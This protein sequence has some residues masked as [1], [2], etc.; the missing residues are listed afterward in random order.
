MMRRFWRRG[1]GPFSKTS[2]T[3]GC[4]V[5]MIS[6]CDECSGY[7]GQEMFGN[8]VFGTPVHGGNVSTYQ[9]PVDERLNAPAKQTPY[10][11]PA[12]K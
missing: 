5:G 12:K 2:R 7:M 3:R 8:P 1:C 10:E 11:G 9:P 4:D 6:G